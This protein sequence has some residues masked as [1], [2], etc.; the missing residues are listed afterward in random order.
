MH[1]KELNI[2]PSIL[3]ALESENYT[4]PT[5]IQ[6]QAIPPILEGRDLLGCA[7]TGT[8]KTAAFAVPTLQL[9]SQD[10][11]AR[12]GPRH[13]RALVLTP[14][15]ELA[16]QIYESFCAYGKH[17]GLRSCVI[18]GGVSQMHQVEKIKNGVDI[19]VATPGRLNDLV[20]QRLVDLQ[21]IKIFILD[22]ADR[23]LDMGF[24][25][26]VKRII[27]KIPYNR[28]TL[29]F[30]ATMPSE[31]ANMVKSLL[32][33]PVK[34]AI[35]PI[36]SP[37]DI[38]DQSLYFVDKE[39]KP[40][41]LLEI[42]KDKSFESVLV[43]TRTKHGADR[44]VKEL[45]ANKINA[46]AIHGNKSQNA[47]QLALSNFK[48]K[49]TRVMVATD[50]AARGIDIDELSLVVNFD[51]PEV[52]ETYVHRIG[53]TGRA[54]HGGTAIAFCNFGEK[55]L[56]V[57][58]EKL[59]SRHITVVEDNPYPLLNTAPVVKSSGGRNSGGRNN[60]PRNTG[61]HNPSE[62]SAS[63]KPSSR[64]FPDTKKAQP[65]RKE[66]VAEWGR[67]GSSGSNKRNPNSRSGV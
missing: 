44:V 2:M 62:M 63:G 65:K 12:T 34:I 5:P 32:K 31:I 61:W 52:P 40:K 14:T 27:L 35:T 16:L 22:E 11:A 45:V 51:L 20:N 7:Q 17:T 4:E 8:G 19:L 15:R 28:Q 18:F 64:R 58:I 26:D 23:M 59:I 42:L 9:L 60:A 6:E 55:E 3:K 37:V 39:N 36:S 24:I 53:R 13:I 48:S 50:I 43:F 41:L 1:F 66:K 54:G 29:L 47:R 21:H 30:S 56:L 33:E 49:I 46:Q 38:I 10:E 25:Y 67:K 57:Q